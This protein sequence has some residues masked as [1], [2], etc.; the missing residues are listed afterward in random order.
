MNGYKR[1]EQGCSTLVI[2]RIY[3]CP[4]PHGRMRREMGK[5]AHSLILKLPS[6]EGRRALSN[7]NGTDAI[8]S[9]FVAE[10]VYELEL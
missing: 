4:S 5:D 1:H 6:R 10:Y 8:R 9:L 3:V 2:R 7:Q